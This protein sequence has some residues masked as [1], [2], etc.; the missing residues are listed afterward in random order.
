M[1]TSH[2]ITSSCSTHWYT[3]PCMLHITSRKGHVISSRQLQ[4]ASGEDSFLQERL[5]GC[6]NC[7]TRYKSHH[8]LLFC[9][10]SARFWCVSK[11]KALQLSA[12]LV[13]PTL[14]TPTNCLQLQLGPNVVSLR[15]CHVF[16]LTGLGYMAL[17]SCT[18]YRTGQEHSHCAQPCLLQDNSVKSR[19]Q[20]N[21]AAAQLR[22]C[23]LCGLSVASSASQH[24]TV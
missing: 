11:V 19:R 7:L 15:T 17:L 14:Q 24:H 10:A 8:N 20:Y 12:G 22:S 9:N 3:V 13:A 2:T 1:P 4:L 21:S 6:F 23:K 5:H 16:D 18:V